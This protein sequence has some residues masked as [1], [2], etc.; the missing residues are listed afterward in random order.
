VRVAALYDVHGNL[1]A[2]EAVL[3]ELDDVRPDLVVFGGDL[4]AGALPRE[5]IA[6]ARTVPKAR[7]VQG[8]ADRVMATGGETGPMTGWPATQIDDADREF[9]GS[10]ELTVVVDGVLYCHATPHDDEPFVTVLSTPEFARE[11]IGE[12]EQPTVVIGHTHSQFDW[13]LGDVRLVNAGSVGMPYEDEPGAY[14]LLVGDGEPERRRTEYDLD[15][16]AARI[17][18]TGW[19]IAGRWAAENLLAVPSAREAAEFFESQRRAR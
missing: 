13:Q 18:A 1:P 19:P 15:A 17:R 11:T 9:L 4:G 10:F 14:W 6:R 2:L 7:F 8:N 16:A 5:T 3:A 12:V